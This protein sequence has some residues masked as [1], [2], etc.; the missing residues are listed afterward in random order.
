VSTARTTQARPVT[1]PAEG[2]ASLADRIAAE[3]RQLRARPDAVA[4]LCADELD[5]LAQLVTFTGAATPGEYRDRLTAL[6]ESRDEDQIR[7][8]YAHGYDAGRRD[9]RDL[10]IQE[11]ISVI[12]RSR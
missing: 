5:R 12:K 2:G 6:E 10:G 11:C 8:A 4:R 9:G 3:A 7:R 1:P